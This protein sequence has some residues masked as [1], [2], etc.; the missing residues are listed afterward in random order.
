MEE[1]LIL[2][3]GERRQALLSEL[4][5]KLLSAMNAIDRILG[6]DDAMLR[7]FL[8]TAS[9]QDG[10][11]SYQ[12]LIE[13]FKDDERGDVERALDKLLDVGLLSARW[14]EV[15]GEENKWERRFYN[16]GEVSSQFEGFSRYAKGDYLAQAS[17]VD[18]F[19]NW[20]ELLE[21]LSGL[22]GFTK[23]VSDKIINYFAH[24]AE[25]LD[26]DHLIIKGYF[27]KPLAYEELW[28]ALSKIK[29]DMPGSG[30]YESDIRYYHPDKKKIAIYNLPCHTWIRT[31]IGIDNSNFQCKMRF[32]FSL[33]DN[34]EATEFQIIPIVNPVIKG[35]NPKTCPH[36]LDYKFCN[37]RYSS[38][39]DDVCIDCVLFTVIK[40]ITLSFIKEYFLANNI[41][42][43]YEPSIDK[44]TWDYFRRKYPDIWDRLKEQLDGI[45]FKHAGGERASQAENSILKMPEFLYKEIK[46]IEEEIGDVLLSKVGKYAKDNGYTILVLPLRKGYAFVKHSAFVKTKIDNSEIEKVLIE[47][48]NFE[49]IIS[50]K[51]FKF[52]L[53]RAKKDGK[54]KK[55]YNKKIII[56]D[57]AI[58]EGKHI[59]QEILD[60]LNAKEYFKPLLENIKIG[61]YIANEKHLDELKAKL[62]EEY[63]NELIED[64]LIGQKVNEH[65]GDL[66]A[67]LK[68]EYGN[69]L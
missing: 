48:Y 15:K 39:Y 59:K 64:T 41:I 46:G 38:I 32:I 52:E 61:A 3:N 58:N 63:G 4:E 17:K 21:R 40:H 12:G 60:F 11:R 62:K 25:I 57:D 26:P 34:A 13:E 16:R 35:G 6:D 53:M 31:N 7:V 20:L 44:Y 68:E 5:E 65:L 42:K 27:K 9:Q 36:D 69:E 8:L 51:E 56:F 24:I 55:W 33:N 37:S 23:E 19:D 22:S 10:G 14:E 43:N 66:K 50:D 18:L 54:L 45:L 2:E 30:I 1:I 29:E 67:K 47:D 28:K 49:D